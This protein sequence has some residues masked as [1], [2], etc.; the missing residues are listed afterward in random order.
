MSV[1]QQLQALHKAHSDSQDKHTY[2]LLA[3]AG[4]AIGFAVQKTEGQPLTWWL[5]PVAA[6]TLLWGVS[7]FLGCRY[8]D[9]VQAAMSANYHLLQLQAGVHREQPRDPTV[10]AAALTGTSKALQQNVD[11]AA[12]YGRW[13][14]LTL[15]AGA[16]LFIAWRVIEMWRQM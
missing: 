7:F 15:V 5:L 11:A 2:F 12:T 6:A 9:R 8:I 10:Q 16:V 3:A 4:A 13:Q 1:E 14:F